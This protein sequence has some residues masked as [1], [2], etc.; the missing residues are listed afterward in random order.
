MPGNAIEQLKDRQ[1][2]D[3]PSPDL[4]YQLSPISGKPAVV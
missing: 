1:I 2:V 3:P 4:L